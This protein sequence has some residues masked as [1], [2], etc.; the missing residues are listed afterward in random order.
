VLKGVLDPHDA[1]LAADLGVDGLVVSNHGGRQ[2]DGAPSA[3]QALPQIAEAVGERL[4]VMADSG[5]RSGLDVVRMLA[6][7]A[8]AVWLGRLW[9]YALAAGGEPAVSAM[10]TDLKRE[11][12]VTMGLAGCRDLSRLTP[13]VLCELSAGRAAQG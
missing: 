3:V 6:M 8:K 1:R 13:E 7:G 12:Q 9:A 4:T 5:V 11:I 10:L 2:L